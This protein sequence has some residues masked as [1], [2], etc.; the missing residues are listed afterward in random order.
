MKKIILV[1]LVISIFS[2][3][4]L[5]TPDDS[6]SFAGNFDYNGSNYTIASGNIEDGQSPGSPY[7][8]SIYLMGS[9]IGFDT[10][11][12]M[13]TGMGNLILFELYSS[14]SGDLADGTYSWSDG[15]PSYGEG[16][17]GTAD[18]YIDYDTGDASSVD[19]FTGLGGSVTISKSDSFYNITFTIFDDIGATIATGSV[20]GVLP[21][22]TD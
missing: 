2:A 11:T 18:L 8:L 9:G 6:V 14:S 19:S 1:F 15:D 3:C 10:G 12:S 20:L 5:T 13:F 4:E 16:T 17:L 22:W 21:I 7:N